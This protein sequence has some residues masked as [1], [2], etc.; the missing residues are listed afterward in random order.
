M[1]KPINAAPERNLLTIRPSSSTAA[2]RLAPSS[3]AAPTSPALLAL[4]RRHDDSDAEGDRDDSTRRSDGEPQREGRGSEDEG[5][6]QWQRRERGGSEDDGLLSRV[7]RSDGG[8][9]GDDGEDTEED[10][11]QQQPPPARRP[12]RVLKQLILRPSVQ[13]QAAVPASSGSA[14][15]LLAPASSSLADWTRCLTGSPDRH[16]VDSGL[17]LLQSAF[18]TFLCYD[19]A[20]GRYRHAA[21]PP[22]A[23]PVAAS[24]ASAPILFPSVLNA[25]VVQERGE[26]WLYAKDALLQ[27]RMQVHAGK[28]LAW[29]DG[30]RRKV[31]TAAQQSRA[32][33]AKEKQQQ[34]LRQQSRSRAGEAAFGDEEDSGDDCGAEPADLRSASAST[35]AELLDGRLLQC[36]H[37]RQARVLLLHDGSRAQSAFQPSDARFLSPKRDGAL[38]VCVRKPRKQE[39]WKLLPLS[40]L[41]FSSLAHAASLLAGLKAKAERKQREEERRL[42]DE[43]W[44]QLYPRDV[45]LGEREI[46]EWRRAQGGGVA[47]GLGAVPG[48][49]GQA[50]HPDHRAARLRSGCG[51]QQLADLPAL[52]LSRHESEDARDASQLAAGSGHRHPA[53][54]GGQ[55]QQQRGT[56]GR[57]ERRGRGGR[58]FC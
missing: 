26:Q 44:Q 41:R 14:E 13:Q 3:A 55:E 42:R 37:T 47:G 24:D 2:S 40:A 12:A 52:Q 9:A 32:D 30:E 58:R 36:A 49:G 31:K 8:D 38:T 39:E 57:G 27:H 25:A 4:K 11:Q 28:L 16:V 17:F 23:A 33:K 51:R 5:E 15:A 1:S 54:Q 53:R 22:P 29:K 19:A 6:E 46:A 56:A 20:G 45:R 48:R 50:A 10:E 35:A 7:F 43:R 18:L 34:Q 21:Y